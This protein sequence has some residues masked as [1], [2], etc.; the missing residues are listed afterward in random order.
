VAS[1]LE[2]G[3]ELGKTVGVEIDVVVGFPDAL[4]IFQDRRTSPD[5]T[6]PRGAIFGEMER[7]VPV[8]RDAEQEVPAGQVIQAGEGRTL[9]ER[10]IE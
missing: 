10:I 9:A 6:G 7:R 2:G 3:S 1:V 8:I 4:A 5:A